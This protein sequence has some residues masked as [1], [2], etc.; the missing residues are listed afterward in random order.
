MLDECCSLATTSTCIST[1]L[2]TSS[3]LFRD[4]RPFPN[5]LRWMLVQACESN[6]IESK[7][8]DTR[9]KQG[10]SMIDLTFRVPRYQQIGI[11]LVLSIYTNSK[12]VNVATRLFAH[13]N[14]A[15]PQVVLYFL[16]A[17]PW[18]GHNVCPAWLPAMKSALVHSRTTTFGNQ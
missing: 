11:V 10:N 2:W 18:D 15:R 14:V 9:A 16:G 6:A 4:G 17:L 8:L 5:Q 3:V 1:S 12:D 7:V 13:C